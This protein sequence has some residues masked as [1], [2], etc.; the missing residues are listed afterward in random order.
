MNIILMKKDLINKLRHFGIMLLLGG[1]FTNTLI[2]P[3]SGQEQPS[4]RDRAEQVFRKYEYAN[5]AALYQK[6]VDR[7]APRV[8]DLERLAY[9]YVQMKDYEAAENWYARVVAMEAS[10]PENL[11]RYG[12]V[13][14]MNGKYAEAKEQLQAYANR[15][16]DGDRVAVQL[17][18]CDSALVWMASP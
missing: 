10:D 2:L 15:T 12:E 5:A 1:F 11:V 14:K 17:A 16:D 9:C 13:L 6:L 3:A 18:G 7:K 4:L 8:A